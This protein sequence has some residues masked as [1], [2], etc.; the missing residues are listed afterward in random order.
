MDFQ[1]QPDLPEKYPNIVLSLKSAGR[2]N[3]IRYF[4][5][6]LVSLG[7]N[8]PEAAKPKEEKK[9]PEPMPAAEPE[10]EP[11][12]ESEES[13]V[14][15]DMEGVIGWLKQRSRGHGGYPRC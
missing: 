14:E 7:A 2:F 6:Y 9:A 3:E 1:E 11:E 13:D 10:P 4:K 8:L 5:D 15:L 12:P